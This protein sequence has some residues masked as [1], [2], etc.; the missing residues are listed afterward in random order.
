MK[1]DGIS[2][3]LLASNGFHQIDIDNALAHLT[4]V[5]SI[6]P[7][8]VGLDANGPTTAYCQRQDAELFQGKVDHV[9][10]VDSLGTAP[11]TSGATVGF[12]ALPRRLAETLLGRFG[13]PSA[14]DIAFYVASGRKT[15]DEIAA[16]RRGTEIAE[17]GLDKL[18]A[19]ARPGTRECD[20]ATEVNLHM[21]ALGA[22]DSF[23]MLNAGPRADA[24]MP[25]SERPLEVGDLLLVELSPSVEGQFVQICRTISIGPAQP[26][27]VE[28]YQLL[29]AAMLNGIERVKPGARLG[30]VCMAIDDHLSTA[31]YAQYSRPPF[32]RRRGHGLAGGSMAPGDVSVDN[33]TVLEPGMVF[34][35]HPNQFLPETGYMMCGEPVVVTDTGYEVMSRRTARLLVAG[36]AA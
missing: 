23:L 29:V 32:I 25:S 14:Y 7:S 36:D 31:G 24:V 15:D 20:I 13:R 17:A 18:L 5:R 19:I 4:G 21:K 22:N 3:L 2:Q 1:R 35:V 30:E 6:G 12:G 10:P 28:K 27:A 16:A 26:V 8:V 11:I 34:V 9:V 33:D